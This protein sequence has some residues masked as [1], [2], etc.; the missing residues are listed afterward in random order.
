MTA[1]FLRRIGRDRVVIR[2]AGSEPAEP[3][4]RHRDRLRGTAQ[5]DLLLCSRFRAVRYSADSPGN[6]TVIVPP[7]RLAYDPQ[8][9]PLAVR[10]RSCAVVR[11]LHGL[12]YE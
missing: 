12:P 1:A 4:P 5:L 9:H 10:A 8:S 6:E 2:S 11:S 3:A 7:D